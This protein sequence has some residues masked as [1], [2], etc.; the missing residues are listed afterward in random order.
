MF[1]NNSIDVFVKKKYVPLIAFS[2]FLNLACGGG[3]GD[4]TEVVKSEG[5]ATLDSTIPIQEESPQVLQNNVQKISE[6]IAPRGMDFSSSKVFKA[7]IQLKDIKIS[8]DELFIKLS[9]FENLKEH[10]FLGK[11]NKQS[12]FNMDLVL[13]KVSN[14]IYYEI[15]SNT[16]GNFSSSLKLN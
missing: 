10:F 9:M 16:G 11:L 3:G 1:I 14:E 8:G 4:S 13:P 6:I 15:Y 12:N 7:S 2:I 5:L